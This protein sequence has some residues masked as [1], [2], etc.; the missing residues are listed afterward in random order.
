MNGMKIVKFLHYRYC[1]Q[2]SIFLYTRDTSD[3][4]ILLDNTQVTIDNI[5]SNY[6]IDKILF[7]M[8]H[9]P[10]HVYKWLSVYLPIMVTE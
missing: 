6:D 4:K 5:K 7:V 3:K 1:K 9:L 8:E 2:L 10:T